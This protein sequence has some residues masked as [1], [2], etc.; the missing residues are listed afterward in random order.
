MIGAIRESLGWLVEDGLNFDPDNV[1]AEDVRKNAT[2]DLHPV[3]ANAERLNRRMGQDT[4]GFAGPFCLRATPEN[5]VPFLRLE[6]RFEPNPIVLRLRVAI[7]YKNGDVD[8][9]KAVGYRFET[10]ENAARHA[11]HHAQPIAKFAGNADSFL[12][13]LPEHALDDAPSLPLFAKDPIGLFA[14]MLVSLYGLDVGG[15]MAKEAIPVSKR[16]SL[17]ILN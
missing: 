5:Y 1:I 6:W 13:G 2:K 11:F 12:P 17:E 7:Y 14:C 10:P 3:Q 15:L 8:D 9:L 4:S 16:A